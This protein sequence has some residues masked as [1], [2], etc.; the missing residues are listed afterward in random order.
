MARGPGAGCPG[1][2]HRAPFAPFAVPPPASHVPP[3]LV[4]QLKRGGRMGIPIGA[5]FQTQQLMLVEQPPDG[6]LTTRQF[7]AG[8][9]VPRTGGGECPKARR[10]P[11]KTGD[12]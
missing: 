6:A 9:F 4:Q 10:R 1:G 12:T 3:P 5:P 2:P 8:T 7:M 11:S